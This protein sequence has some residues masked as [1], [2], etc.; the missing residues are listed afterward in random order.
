MRSRGASRGRSFVV[1]RRD[2]VT[3]QT[4]SRHRRSCYVLCLITSAVVYWIARSSRATTSED[5]VVVSPAHAPSLPRHRAKWL[6]T[7]VP[8]AMR[9][10][11]R[12]QAHSPGHSRDDVGHDRPSPPRNGRP[13]TSRCSLNARIDP[14][15]PLRVATPRLGHGEE[16]ASLLRSPK[17]HIIAAFSSPHRPIP[18]RPSAHFRDT[19]G[20]PINGKDRP[21][22]P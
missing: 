22:A 3:Q 9:G 1:T 17:P 13:H 21:C 16:R 19:A 7:C 8:P 2:R 20:R 14:P 11:M 18:S 15:F 6:F 10:M 5:R 4:P 12:Q